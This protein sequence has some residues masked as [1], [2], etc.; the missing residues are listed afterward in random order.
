MAV[1]FGTDI[2]T[3]LSGDISF[4]G[5]GDLALAGCTR[6]YLD[7]IAFIAR[8]ETNDYT[9]TTK[10]IGADLYQF[11]GQRL[12]NILISEVETKLKSALTE[13]LIKQEDLTLYAIPISCEEIMIYI[14]VDGAF[15]NNDG[16]LDGES[17]EAAFTFPMYEG[18]GVT[19]VN[20]QA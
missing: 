8:T 15:I 10:R 13:N 1:Y 2:L 19:I 6:T 17:F 7:Q 5:N 3:D 11:I 9:A 14:K 16:V 4:S 20:Y 12:D 18:D